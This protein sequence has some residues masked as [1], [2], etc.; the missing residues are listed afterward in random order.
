MVTRKRCF[1]DRSDGR[2]IRTLNP[3]TRIAI[4]IMK[5][6]NDVLNYIRDSIDT[7]QI[8]KYILK[9]ARRD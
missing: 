9:S 5:D 6:R 3:M 4:F 1:G 7:A 8:D 2:K